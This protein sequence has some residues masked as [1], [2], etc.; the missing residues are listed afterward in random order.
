M[1]TPPH[2]RR[3]VSVLAADQAGPVFDYEA[4]EG[5]MEESEFAARQYAKQVPIEISEDLAEVERGWI[6]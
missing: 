3:K 4:F 6:R 1:G 2:G 5:I